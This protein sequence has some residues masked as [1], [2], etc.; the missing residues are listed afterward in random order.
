MGANTGEV[1]PRQGAGACQATAT[2]TE[3]LMMVSQ[4][5]RLLGAFRRWLTGDRS[6]WLTPP[7]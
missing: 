6:V 3:A 1:V 4:V 7:T 5:K 2:A